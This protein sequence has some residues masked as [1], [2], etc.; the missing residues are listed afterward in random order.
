MSKSFDL[1]RREFSAFYY[2]GFL[3]ERDEGHILIKFNFSVDKRFEFNHEIIIK[4]DNLTL[5]NPVNGETARRLVFSLGLAEAVSYWKAI[6]PKRFVVRCG[7]LSD[8]QIKWWKKLWFN[9]LGEFFFI[10]GIQT[11]IESF[12]A[13]E[14]TLPAPKDTADTPYVKS[15]IN[16]VPV[17]GGKDSAVTLAL[18]KDISDTVMCFTVNDHQARTD[19]AA[20]AGLGKGRIIRSYREMDK[21]LLRLNSEGYLNGHTPFSSV[22]AFLSL[23]S[24]YLTG[25]ENVIL[26]NESSANE[27]SVQGLSVN[28][29]YSKSYEFEKDFNL[30]T[31]KHLRLPVTYF[32]LLRPFCELQIAK[33]FASLPQFHEA[34]KS[35]NV[36][37][38][39]NIW[40]RN[41]AKCLFVYIILSPFLPPE[42]LFEIFGCNMLEKCELKDDFDGMTGISGAKPFECVGTVSEVNFALA[43][44]AERYKKLGL[45]LPCLLDYFSSVS[46]GVGNGDPF[47]SFDSKNNIPKDFIKYA[48]EMLAFVQSAD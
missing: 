26:S 39:K 41:C 5:L 15:G 9:G 43:M 23:Y 6:C 1:L 36:G 44:T 20:A 3:I 45:P 24:A 18:L 11:D 38:K 10:N 35:C 27:P 34:F 12:I 31:S 47:S 21:E 22:V 17:G 46:H 40:C 2:D 19:T 25:A 16:I 29:Q 33:M 42:R 48:K 14:N 13:V 7:Y 37:S 4:T 8:E 32:S 28:H 30:Y